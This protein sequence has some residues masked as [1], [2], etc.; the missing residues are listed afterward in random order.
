MEFLFV[1][2]GG[3]SNNISHD[4]LQETFSQFGK[5][6]DIVMQRK[7]PYSFVIYEEKQSAMLAVE[8]LQATEITKNQT[9]IFFYI[10]PVDKG[11]IKLF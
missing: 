11:F 1:G 5:I 6:T 10:F 3:L 7:K 4:F 8:K 9:P 2:N